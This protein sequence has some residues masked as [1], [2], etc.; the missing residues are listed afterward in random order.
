MRF[1][2]GLRPG[3][4]LEVNLQHLLK[5]LYLLNVPEC[6]FSVIRKLEIKYCVPVF[7]R[8]D[9]ILNLENTRWNEPA[10]AIIINFTVSF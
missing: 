8:V 9:S 1:N 4:L 5:V 7:I 6:N 2:H 3:I 10:I